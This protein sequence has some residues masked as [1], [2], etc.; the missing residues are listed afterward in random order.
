MPK[1]STCLGILL[2]F[3]LAPPVR[4]QWSSVDSGTTKALRGVYLLDSGVAYAVGD[5]GTILKSTDAG[6]SWSALASGT[7]R[8]LYDLYFFS[9]T[10][11]LAVGDNGLIQRTTDGGATWS[12]VASGVRDG[13]RS[14]SFNG[15]NGICG[16]LSQDILYSSDSGA[17]W[18]VS[19]KG[20]FGGGFFG[21]HMLSPTVG[22]V[23]GQN[24]I[25]QGLEGTTVDGGVH[26][27]FHVFYF[28]GNE[29]N[30]DDN[31]FFD[32]TTGVTSGVLFDNTGAIARTTNGG[33]D[34]TSTIFPQGMQGIDFPQP[35]SGFAVGY[36]GTIQHSS[37]MGATW[38]AQTSGTGLDLY[39][40]DF[41]S[42]ALTGLAVGASGTIL[43][44]T[45]GGEEGGLELIAAVSRKNGFDVE[46]PLSGDPAIEC[47]TDDS[48]GD[49]KL[50][51]T[52]NNA[53]TAVDDAV[54]S[55]GSI[56]RVEIDQTDPHQLRV[57]LSAPA[58]NAEF[59]TVTVEGIDDDQGHTLAQAAVTLGLLL[60]DVN[61]D[62]V[63]DRSDATQVRQ[64]H[65][66]RTDETN[67]REDIDSSGRIKGDDFAIV[68]SE[69]GSMLPH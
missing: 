50:V 20:F 59:V 5:A 3:C 31:F 56:R 52:F 64:D 12:S 63:V 60:G 43:R 46:L 53:L 11:G 25:F 14:V 21:A 39:D 10:E 65:G 26:W 62:G 68:R 27:S 67:F 16:G 23:T 51:L 35:E 28:N 4:A 40:V 8:N 45:D 41:A 15:A 38:S 18:Q 58:C 1:I 13:L 29:G 36:F 34:W 66:A 24:S 61:G 57:T 44:T 37:D 47:R 32:D 9:E 48:A 22:F 6:A 49:Q 7:T 54:T 42:D 19:Q 55:C 30:A 17:T 33:A 2:L 69:N